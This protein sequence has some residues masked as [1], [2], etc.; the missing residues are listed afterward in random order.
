MARFNASGNGRVR[1]GVGRRLECKCGDDL[2][3]DVVSE[4]FMAYL[5]GPAVMLMVGVVLWLAT[6]HH[7]NTSEGRSSRWLDTHYVDLMHHRH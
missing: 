2:K 4:T 6:R 3:E 5:M 7:G 1:V